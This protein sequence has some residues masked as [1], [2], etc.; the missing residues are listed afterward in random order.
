MNVARSEIFEENDC[1]NI[2]TVKQS[3]QWTDRTEIN[4]KSM[5]K[6]FYKLEATK[7]DLPTFKNNTGE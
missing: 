1:E 5:I 3:T 2:V 6:S 4:L 7:I